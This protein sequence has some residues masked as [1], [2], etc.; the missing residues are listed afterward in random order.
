MLN[1]LQLA[2]TNALAGLAVAAL[3]FFTLNGCV[4]GVVSYD[5]S[6]GFIDRCAGMSW[7]TCRRQRHRVNE[8]S[9]D[10]YERM[11]RQTFLDVSRSVQSRSAFPIERYSFVVLREP[12][13]PFL[14]ES[15]RAFDSRGERRYVRASAETFSTVG[16]LAMARHL[17]GIGR[18]D[19]EWASRYLVSIRRIP[20]GDPI[21]DPLRVSGLISESAE[22][23]VSAPDFTP[24]IREAIND[25][26]SVMQFVMAHEIYH[27]EH[28]FHCN[29]SPT[30]CKRAVAAYEVEADQFAFGV[31]ATLAAKES[32]PGH[33]LAVPTFLFSMLM[34]T[35]DRVETLDRGSSHPPNFERMRSSIEALKRWMI[36][37]PTSSA[38]DNL[39]EVVDIATGILA[40]IDSNGPDAYLRALDEEAQAVDRLA[41][42]LY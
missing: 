7:E 17:V 11:L 20:P 2:H 42:R 31:M 10:V 14:V 5:D 23:A 26:Y 39:Q 40:D 12:L 1:P 32:D 19:L 18:I 36:A 24:A 34:L 9:V 38:A 15:Q 8:A 33:H 22:V 35:M 13:F 29:A 3:A 41:L 6:F 37:N 4:S 21:V 30:E 25:T 16:K 27:L 28:P